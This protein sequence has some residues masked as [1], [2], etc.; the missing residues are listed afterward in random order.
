MSSHPS[1]RLFCLLCVW[2]LSGL[3]ASISHFLGEVY[4]LVASVSHF[5][6]RVLFFWYFICLVSLAPLVAYFISLCINN[7]LPPI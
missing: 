1:D 5:L 3:V 6:D 2:K 7:Y 4:G